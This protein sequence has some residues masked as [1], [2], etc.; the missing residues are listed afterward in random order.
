MNKIK[1]FISTLMLVFTVQYATA[2]QATYVLVHGAWGGAWQFKNTA[3]GLTE[4][5]DVVYRPTMTGLGERYHLADSTV[6]LSVHIQDVINT[7]LFEDLHDI[8]LVGHSY[9]GMIVTA[10]ADSIPERIKKIVYLDAILPENN[11]SVVDVMRLSSF[12][13]LQ[14]GNG[15]ID[16]F[17]VKDTSKFPRDVPHPIHT[18]ADKISLNNEK[19]NLI[20]KTYILTYEGEDKTKDDF[21]KFYDRA[22]TKNYKLIEM[23]ADHNPQIKNLKEL[24]TLLHNEK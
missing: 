22:K 7:I 21:Y 1:L 23:H 14:K 17:W 11:E 19:R 20:P 16:P 12:G 13:D 18:F 3:L 8:I 6:G 10:V 2:Q 4:Y 15:F 9:G 24:V 5:G